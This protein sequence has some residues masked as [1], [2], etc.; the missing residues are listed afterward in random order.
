MILKNNSEKNIVNLDKVLRKTDA[1]QYDEADYKIK[2]S[3]DNPE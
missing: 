1:L 2:Q 3:I